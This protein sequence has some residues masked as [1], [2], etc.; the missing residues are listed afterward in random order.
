MRCKS[1]VKKIQFV[2]RPCNFNFQWLK[3]K[4]VKNFRDITVDV[5]KKVGQFAHNEQFISDN[6]ECNLYSLD[7]SSIVNSNS[8]CND[9]QLANNNL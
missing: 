2:E 9:K 3:S 4:D 1:Q 5:N 8:D 6:E 7:M